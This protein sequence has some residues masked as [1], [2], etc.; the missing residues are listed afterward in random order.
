MREKE[1]EMYLVKR[2]KS[3]GG[4]CYKFT[5]P[6]GAGVPDRIVILNGRLHF[7]E[8][9]ATGQKPRPL[10]VIQIERLRFQGQIVRVADSKEKIDEYLEVMMC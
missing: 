3:L 10:Q 8:L 5:S 6:N 7:F 2:V 4:L 1:I 9:K